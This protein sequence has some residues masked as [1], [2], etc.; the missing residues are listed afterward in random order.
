MR[1]F[2]SFIL[3]LL[4]ASIA[5]ISAAV[6]FQ[7]PMGRS[8][9]PRDWESSGSLESQNVALRR[10]LQRAISIEEQ[11]WKRAETVTTQALVLGLLGAIGTGV[12]MGYAGRSSTQ[13]LRRYQSGLEQGDRTQD[14]SVPPS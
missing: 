8:K 10:S 13:V 7:Y 12:A 4:F 14:D 11:T 6:L 2:P 3:L 5:V 9:I 1:T